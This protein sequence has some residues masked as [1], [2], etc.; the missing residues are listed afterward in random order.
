MKRVILMLATVLGSSPFHS[1]SAATIPLVSHGD[2]WRYHK[3]TNAPQGGWK[4]MADSSLDVTWAT[5]Y[6]GFGFADNT[7]E[8]GNCQTLLPD[9]KGSA[10]TNYLTLYMRKQFTV[11]SAP[12]TNLHLFLRMD[13]D[14]GY[15]A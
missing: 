2:A 14:D 10:A 11:A 7:T 5:G 12:A 8:T 6:G 3:G 1:V 9:M 15:I 4:S 13:F